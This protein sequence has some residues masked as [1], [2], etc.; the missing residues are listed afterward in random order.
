MQPGDVKYVDIDK[1]GVINDDDRVVLGNAFPRYVFG[2]NY[3]FSWKGLDFSML[4][5]GVGKRDMALRGEMIEA[6]HGSYSYVI[7]EHQL[8][9]WTPDNRDARY[10]RLINV[11]SSSYQ[12]NYKHSSD[13]NLYNAAYLRLKDIQIGYTI[14]ASYTIKIGM[15]KVRVFMNCQN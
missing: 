12:H 2:F 13:R 11:A 7:Y 6:F 1:N 14:H 9:Y 8:D 3:N 15:K 5:Q 4:W 10:P